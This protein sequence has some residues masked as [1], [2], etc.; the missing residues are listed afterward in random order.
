M[1][2]LMHHVKPIKCASSLYLGL[3]KISTR[4]LL[5]TTIEKIYTEKTSYFSS[6]NGAGEHCS[7]NGPNPSPACTVYIMAVLQLSEKRLT[8]YR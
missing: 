5:F 4:F 8:S 1:S 7:H 3:F 2:I 6:Q